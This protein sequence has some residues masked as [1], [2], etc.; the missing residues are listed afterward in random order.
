MSLTH[1]EKLFLDRHRR[2]ESQAAAASRH[3][4]SL[5]RYQ[6][7]ERGYE[8]GLVV[9]VGDI[10]PFERCIIL[11]RREGLT[12]T[13]ASKRIGVSMWWLRKMETGAANPKRLIEFWD[14]ESRPWRDSA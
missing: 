11:R 10:L 8:G 6:R 14:K 13:E 7:E 2:M 5:Y 3:R 4:V 1:G 12:S 9:E